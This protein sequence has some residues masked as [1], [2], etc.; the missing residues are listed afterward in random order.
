MLA[1]MHSACMRG[2]FLDYSRIDR[3]HAAS[4]SVRV[5]G[6]GALLPPQLVCDGQLQGCIYRD[7]AADVCGLKAAAVSESPLKANG[8]YG[9]DCVATS[10]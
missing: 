9:R 10:V 1:C 6:R 5:Q 3:R 8:R 2:L 7:H 4:G